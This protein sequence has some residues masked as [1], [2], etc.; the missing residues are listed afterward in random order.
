MGEWRQALGGE[1]M[2]KNNEELVTRISFEVVK[3]VAPDEAD[4]FDDI[5]EE[6]FKNPEAFEEKDKEKRE[7]MLGFSAP[8]GAD[9]FVSTIVLPLVWKALTKLG[10]GLAKKVDSKLSENKFKI[11]R[12]EAYNNAI[13]MGLEKEKAE[14]MA[15]ALLGRLV[16]LSGAK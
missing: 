4:L 14:L 11:V 5:K 13:A 3:E 7:E 8:V 15:D 1:Y 2:D 12:E 6:F 16:R 9:P 10:E